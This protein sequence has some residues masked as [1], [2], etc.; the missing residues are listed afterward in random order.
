MLENKIITTEMYSGNVK[1]IKVAAIGFGSFSQERYCPE[2]TE[3]ENHDKA[4]SRCLSMFG[5]M[6]IISKEKLCDNSYA[7]YVK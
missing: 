4:A 7:Y 6:K 1:Q 3:E 2:K 5:Y